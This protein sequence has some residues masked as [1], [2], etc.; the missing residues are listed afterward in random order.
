MFQNLCSTN[1]QVSRSIHTPKV[2]E[3]WKAMW[4]G[5]ILNDSWMRRIEHAVAA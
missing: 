4:T 1:F 2:T 3:L 5:K